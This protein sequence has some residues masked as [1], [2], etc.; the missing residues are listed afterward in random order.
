MTLNSVM[1]LKQV[2]RL[3]HNG[4]KYKKANKIT[5]VVIYNLSYSKWVCKY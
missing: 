4:S 3:N 1:I 2:V 5:K